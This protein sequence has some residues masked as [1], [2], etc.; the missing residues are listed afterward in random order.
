MKKTLE[1]KAAWQRSLGKQV[2]EKN[3]HW[4]G[5]YMYVCI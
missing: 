3:W 1:K 5:I 4:A 2:E